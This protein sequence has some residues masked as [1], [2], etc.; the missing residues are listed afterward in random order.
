MGGQFSLDFP[1]SPPG[2]RRERLYFA[3]KLDALAA[4]REI[5]PI[6]W[7]VRDFL[8]VRSHVGQGRHDHLGRWPLL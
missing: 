4:R 2:A 7:L 1:D 8:L 3:L 6:R 5:R